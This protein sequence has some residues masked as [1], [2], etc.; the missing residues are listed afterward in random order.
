[1]KLDLH[2]LKITHGVFRKVVD[3]GVGMLEFMCQGKEGGKE[4]ERNKIFI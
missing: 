2:I 1:M 4:N 3:M